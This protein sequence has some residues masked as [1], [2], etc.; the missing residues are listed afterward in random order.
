LYVMVS[1]ASIFS[2]FCFS[3]HLKNQLFFFSL[4]VATNVIILSNILKHLSFLHQV[5]FELCS[6]KIEK[7]YIMNVIMLIF[8]DIKR[9]S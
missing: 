6:K 8:T 9:D 3:S 5:V 4:Y 1:G 7:I 2:E